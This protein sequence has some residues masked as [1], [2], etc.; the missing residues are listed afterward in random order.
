M[1]KLRVKK[2]APGTTCEEA[3]QLSHNFYIP[4]GMPAMFVVRNRDP[5]S[6]NMCAACASHNVKDRGARYV[7]EDENL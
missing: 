7:M 3:S 2:P 4:C 5:D 1:N 6:Y